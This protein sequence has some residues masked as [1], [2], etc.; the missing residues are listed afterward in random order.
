MNAQKIGY[1]NTDKILSHIGEYNVAQQKL[2]T[3]NKQYKARVDADYAVIKKMYDSYQASKSRMSA[4]QRSQ[5][6]NEIINKEQNVKNLQKSFF[7]QDGLMQKKSEELLSPIKQRVQNIINKVAEKYGYS[8]IFDT[9]A[10]HGLVYEN[11]KMNLN[12]IV[13]KELNINK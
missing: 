5:K 12:D 4:S 10:F 11:E 2:E 8:F 7:G 13:L 9:A 6:E 3:L 1:V